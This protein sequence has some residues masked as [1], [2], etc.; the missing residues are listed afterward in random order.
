MSCDHTPA[1]QMSAILELSIVGL[2][3]PLGHMIGLSSFL[4]LDFNGW[5]M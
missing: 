2:M 5:G 3:M 4:K 1:K